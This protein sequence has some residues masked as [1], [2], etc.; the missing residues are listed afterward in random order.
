MHADKTNRVVLLGLGFVLL[1]AGVLGALAGFGAFGD[2]IKNESLVANPVG[3]FFGTHGAW[4]WPV[5][6]VVAAIVALLALRW[7]W[8]LLFSTDRVN[9]VRLRGSRAAGRTTVVV[10]ALT[11]AVSDEIAHYRGVERASARLIGDPATPTLVI[12]AVLDYAADPDQLRRRIEQEAV[13]H[14]RAALDD[15]ELAVQ[16]DLNVTDGETPRVR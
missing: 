15:R 3:R 11:D 1:A 16:L 4:L 8:V 6:A 2:R 13:Q 7:L 10:A 12:D 14:A 9:E 5:V